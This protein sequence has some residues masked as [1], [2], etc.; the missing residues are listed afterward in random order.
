MLKSLLCG[1]LVL[2]LESSKHDI[3]NALLIPLR[4]LIELVAGLLLRIAQKELIPE[5]KKICLLELPICLKRG[6]SIV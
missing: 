4:L 6:L 2:I 3:D 1:I 5:K